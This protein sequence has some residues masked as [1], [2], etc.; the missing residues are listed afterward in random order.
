MTKEE[1]HRLQNVELEIMDEIHRICTENDIEYFLIGGSAIGAVRHNGMIPWDVDIDVGMTRPDYERFG[2]YCR[3]KLHSDL[4]EYHDWHNTKDYIPPHGTFCK[5]G[6][7]IRTVYA[8]YNKRER[9][10]GIFVDIIPHDN[11]PNSEKKVKKL[12]KKLRFVQ[13]IKDRK[14]CYFY[15]DYDNHKM[16]HII[17]LIISKALFWISIKRLN[18]LEEKIMRSYENVNTDYLAAMAGKYSFAQENR[19]K[20]VYGTPLLVPF[21]GRHYYVPEKVD[22]YLT[23]TY[24]DYMKIPP[25]DEQ[26][27]NYTYF[28]KVKF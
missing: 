22:E 12:E 25:I 28:E 10:Y 8:K 20:K 16:E 1:F 9:E 4:Y 18:M 17:K 13:R 6:T 2:E 23:I 11:A 24:G 14:I 7:E 19:P 26:K 27:I 3:N 5:K 21:S 15:N